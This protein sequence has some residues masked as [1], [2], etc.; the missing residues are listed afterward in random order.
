MKGML[1]TLEAILATV[2]ILVGIIS[3]FPIQEQKETMFSD[4]GRYCLTYLDNSGLL[5]Y[6][7]VNDMSVD[8]ANS[9]RN[10]LPSVTDFRVKIC[11][12]SDC[13]ETITGQETVYLS[14]YIIAGDNAYNRK[15]I[16]LWVWR[17]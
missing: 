6:Y 15:L 7:A 5:R 13:T 16:N 14:S 8:L 1:Y 3:I 10:C 11:S 4:V 12:S 2:M 17:K 9:L